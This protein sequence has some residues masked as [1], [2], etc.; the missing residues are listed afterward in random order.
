MRESDAGRRLVTR[1]LY[2]VRHSKADPHDGPLSQVGERQAQLTGQRLK[3]VPFRG[4]YH[5]LRP[6]AALAGPE[7]DELRADGPASG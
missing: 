4:V 3:D 2:V 6:R 1:F 7:P 5:G